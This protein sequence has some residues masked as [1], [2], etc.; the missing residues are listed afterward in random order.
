MPDDTKEAAPSAAGPYSGL[1]K[2]IQEHIGKELRGFYNVM[3]DKPAYLGDP[4]LPAEL[5]SKLLQ[6]S[7]RLAVSQQGA[8]AV[9]EALGIEPSHPGIK[10]QG[11][12]G[13]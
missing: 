6:L 5:Q 7:R 13:S 3:A 12:G 11:E 10:R 1:E 4:T 9:K 2:L 8:E